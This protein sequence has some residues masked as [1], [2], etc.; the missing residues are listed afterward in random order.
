MWLNDKFLMIAS[1][2]FVGTW[3][4]YMLQQTAGPEFAK[5]DMNHPQIAGQ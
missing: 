3:R 2:G 4:K 5:N 1:V